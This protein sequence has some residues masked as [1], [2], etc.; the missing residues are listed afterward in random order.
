MFNG[1]CETMR[2]VGRGFRSLK[3]RSDQS[4]HG[5]RR[6]PH[7]LPPLIGEGQHSLCEATQSSVYLRVRSAVSL[8]GHDKPMEFARGDL[9]PAEQELAA[10]LE[11]GTV[12]GRDTEDRANWPVIRAKIIRNLLRGVYKD[13]VPDP[14]G[15]RLR[16][17]RIAGRIDLDHLETRIL[18]SLDQCDLPEG[19]TA[20]H[21]QLPILRLRGMTI[22]R[23]SELSAVL[24]LRGLH[25]AEL[26]LTGTVL[27]NN[28]GPALHADGIAIDFDCSLGNGFA[29]TGHGHLGT[30]RLLGATIGGQLNFRGAK[31][32]N[33]ENRDSETGPALSADGITVGSDAYL[34]EKFSATGHGRQGAIRLVGATIGGQL[35]MSRACLIN[36]TG[37]ALRAEGIIVHSDARFCDE[38][39]A[40]GHGDLGAVRLAGA[41]IGGQLVLSSAHFPE[42]GPE[43]GVPA[44]VLTGADVRSDLSIDEATLERESHTGSWLIDGLTYRGLNAESNQWLKF[45]RE[46]TWK[47]SPQPYQQFAAVARAR[48]DEK[49][50]RKILIAQHSDLLARNRSRGASLTWGQR[51][52][53]RVLWAT[54]GYGYK[55]WLAVLWLALVV[56]VAVIAAFAFG[57]PAWHWPWSWSWLP[58]WSAAALEQPEGSKAGAPCQ[59]VDLL[60]LGLETIPLIPLVS[61]ANDSCAVTNSAAGITFLGVSVALKIAAWA[62]VTLF[63]A[64]YSNIVRKPGP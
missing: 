58:G 54:V 37:P 27:T 3:N 52:G 32:N 12:Y 9:E 44:V 10:A 47:Y 1:V 46:G 63:V 22:D 6:T 48:G 56:A 8:M 64:G 20:V 60:V 62:L 26:D 36:K 2:R 18:L 43:S 57:S 29:A 51:A 31:L 39:T 13:L 5:H 34:D 14:M 24:R 41:T 55:T 61:G 23:H 49:L 21:A 35:H 50:T 45:L 7:L 42:M 30:V 33:L 38:F 25:A 19:L 4:P 28:Q 17:V 16:H 40:M 15:L 53:Q 59:D 11:A